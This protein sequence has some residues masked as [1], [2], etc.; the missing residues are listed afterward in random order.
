MSQHLVLVIQLHAKHRVGQRLNDSCDHFNG[1]FL[2]Q[3]AF[4]TIHDLPDVLR[5]LGNGPKAINFDFSAMKYFRINERMRV[6]FR[7]VMT[8]VFNHAN[9]SNPA[10]NISSTGTVGQITSTFQE[11]IGEASRQVHFGLRVEF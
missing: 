9:F 6:Q 7:T 4:L 5:D 2:R 3:S 1:I 11:Q 8:N 10:A